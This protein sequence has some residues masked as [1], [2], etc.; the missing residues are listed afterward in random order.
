MY[1]FEQHW[2]RASLTCSGCIVAERP[3][4]S[5]MRR[6]CTRCEQTLPLVIENPR[7][8]GRAWS[9]ILLRGVLDRG[10]GQGQWV[11]YECQYPECS[12]ADCRRRS[13]FPVTYI[14]NDTTRYLC[15]A[16]LWPPCAGAGCEEPRPR[17]PEYRSTHL[18]QWQCKKCRPEASRTCVTCGEQRSVSDFERQPSGQ[19]HK[20]CRVCK[21]TKEC[22]VCGMRK[23]SGEVVHGRSGNVCSTCRLET[24]YT[25]TSCGKD[26]PKKD[27]NLRAGGKPHSRCNACDNIHECIKCKVKKPFTEFATSL[28][29]TCRECETEAAKSWL[30]CRRC[31]TEKQAEDFQNPKDRRRHRDHCH[32][33][34]KKRQCD[35]EGCKKWYDP[36]AEGWSAK[37][38]ILVCRKCKT[39]RGCTD[40]DPQLYHCVACEQKQ[41]RSRYLLKD[42][43]N[44]SQKPTWTLRCTAC[45]TAR[46]AK[47]HLLRA[48]QCFCFVTFVRECT[49]ALANRECTSLYC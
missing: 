30:L 26:K 14:E 15:Q 21:M 35:V 5:Q 4:F 42:I 45:K 36:A 3:A 10:A 39:D 25:C 46:G 20:V 48:L 7:L 17:A 22:N 27:F 6:E 8:G 13:K 23:P 44:Y 32:D 2:F 28:K 29:Q 33:C 1:T 41:G 38:K 31:N 11:C 9:P 18:A 34:A 24:K 16:C 12:N 40:K 49:T 19:M 47:W 37:Q 43:N